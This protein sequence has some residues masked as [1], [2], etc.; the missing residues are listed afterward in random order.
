MNENQTPNKKKWIPIVIIMIV[1]AGI[2]VFGLV[3]VN[4]GKG[5][6]KDSSTQA[7]GLSVEK[8]KDVENT[9]SGA[10]SG[11]GIASGNGLS[12][13]GVL[14]PQSTLVADGPSEHEIVSDWEADSIVSLPDAG[15]YAALPGEK[16]QDGSTQIIRSKDGIFYTIYNAGDLD[17]DMLN[18]YVYAYVGDTGAVNSAEW[19]SVVNDSGYINGYEA[20]Y[21]TGYFTVSYADG[22]VA[23]KYGVMYHVTYDDAVSLALGAFSFNPEQLFPAKDILDHVIYSL[24]GRGSE[25]NIVGGGEDSSGQE[26]LLIED[27]L[28]IIHNVCDREIEISPDRTGDGYIVLQWTSIYFPYSAVITNSEGRQIFKNDG[29]TD[30]GLYVYNVYPSSPSGTYTLH[31]DTTDELGHCTLNY[32]SKEV[33]N[34]YYGY[35]DEDGSPAHGLELD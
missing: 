35:P 2:L 13:D 10:S 32:Y 20:T 25:L 19:S 21:D 1:L 29:L 31:L 6:G 30:T 15:I 7:A 23:T 16:E 5:D 12:V 9:Q 24:Y 17:T 28:G 34:M 14:Y 11:N 8:V 26:Y 22:T 4:I 18:T 3:L 27:D 33:F